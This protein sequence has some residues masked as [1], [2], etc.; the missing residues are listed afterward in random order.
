MAWQR[1][2]LRHLA[3]A[4]SLTSR[5]HLHSAEVYRYLAL[6]LAVRDRPWGGRDM[7]VYQLECNQLTGGS[8]RCTL[9]IPFNHVCFAASLFTPHPAFVEPGTH[10]SPHTLASTSVPHHTRDSLLSSDL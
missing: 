2:L 10:P 3:I 4:V 6:A 9:A 1:T 7:Y 8:E 5:R